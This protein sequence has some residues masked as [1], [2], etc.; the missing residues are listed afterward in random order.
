M[1]A[2]TPAEPEHET[3]SLQRNPVAQPIVR[4]R[5]LTAMDQP[6]PDIPSCG[7]EELVFVRAADEIA[8]NMAVFGDLTTVACRRAAAFGSEGERVGRIVTRGLDS[9]QVVKLLVHAGII[10]ATIH[11][12]A[13][14]A[15]AAAGHDVGGDWL[16]L[17]SDATYWTN[18]EHHERFEFGVRISV[19]G[20]IRVVNPRSLPK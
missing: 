11:V 8:V 18:R 20:E 10:D 7:F 19:T 5:R 3:W 9:R 6:V 15:V 12:A 4:A 16:L 13:T 14:V 2:T 1:H 17:T